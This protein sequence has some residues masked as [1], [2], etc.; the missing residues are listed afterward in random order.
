MGWNYGGQ[1]PKM[2]TTVVLDHYPKAN[3]PELRTIGAVQSMVFEAGQKPFYKLNSTEDFAGVPKGLKQVLWE[4]GLLTKK[5]TMVGR[6]N[7]DGTRR[8]NT[9]GVEKMAC[10]TDFQWEFT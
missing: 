3:D 6:R 10:Q 2:H 8:N 4:R 1:Q 5:T 9:C 7:D